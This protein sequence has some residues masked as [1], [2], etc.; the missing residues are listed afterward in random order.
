MKNKKYNAEAATTESKLTD[1]INEAT[2]TRRTPVRRSE[3]VEITTAN[4]HSEGS[5]D[6]RW[7]SASPPPGTELATAS[8]CCQR[9]H[10]Q[11]VMPSLR[12]RYRPTMTTQEIKP[13]NIGDFV[14]EFGTTEDVRKIFG[15]KKGTLYNL[16]D[17]GKVRGKVCRVTGEFK[18]VRLWNMDSIR[19]YIESQD[20]D[21]QIGGFQS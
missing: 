12:S 18:G 19:A 15:F 3:F 6:P 14:Q 16:H 11:A 4:L 10:V 8:K 17:M 13:A 21:I 20:D 1:I 2:T 7:D 5:A 9:D